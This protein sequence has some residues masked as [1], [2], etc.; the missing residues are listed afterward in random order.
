MMDIEKRLNKLASELIDNQKDNFRIYD[1]ELKRIT[2]IKNNAFGELKSLKERCEGLIAEIEKI[3]NDF[4][5]EMGSVSGG[6]SISD[7]KI[8]REYKN[9]QDK[10]YSLLSGLN[11]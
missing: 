10:F 3:R 5:E 2:L 8:R 1:R 7:M 4:D 11:I 6:I 9:Y